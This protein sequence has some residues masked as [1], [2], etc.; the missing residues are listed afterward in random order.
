MAAPSI[1]V[2]CPKGHPNLL[3][4]EIAGHFGGVKI[5]LF[6][7]FEMGKTNKTE[8]YFK[9]NPN[10]QIPTAVTSD[11]PIFES[12]AIA[13]YVARVGSDSKGL[14]GD[15][16]YH[17][18]QVDQWVNFARSRLEGLYAL[19]GFAFGHGKYDKEKWDE[20]LKK[21]TDAFAV[22][23]KHLTNTGN[24]YLVGSRV[25]LADIIVFC[26]VSG[27]L[28]V[29]VT[30]ANLQPYPKTHAYLH[31]LFQ[32]EHIVAVTGPLAFQTTFT[33]PAQ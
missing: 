5:E 11:G 33:P 16:P 13:Y 27:A 6:D 12:N 1:R 29:S 10:G 2:Y 14:L 18:A 3:K 26:S 7:G 9:L 28:R 4:S 17:Q 23:E 30:E 24:K 15:T 19:F 8:E 21:V 31:N 32:N 22:I 25:T 20:A